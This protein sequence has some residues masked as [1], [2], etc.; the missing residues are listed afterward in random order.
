MAQSI[1]AVPPAGPPAELKKIGRPPAEICALFPLSDE[2]RAVFDP[3]LPPRDFVDRLCAGGLFPDAVRFLAYALPKRE[4]VWWACLAAR[5]ALGEGAPKPQ[6]DALAAAEAWVY[7]PE[8]DSRRAAMASANAAGLDNPASWAAVAAFWS[9][10][11]LA[12]PDAPVVPPGDTLTAGAVAGAV[13]LGAVQREP[14]RAPEKYRLFIA[15]ALDI[16]RG[17]NGRV[18]APG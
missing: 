13:L 18:D 4:A 6:A 12:P 9:D 16:A 7:K 10:G 15:Q 3:A 8:E 2:G 11:S 17:G 1:P 5:A 14:D